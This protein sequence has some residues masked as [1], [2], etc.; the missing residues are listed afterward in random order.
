LAARSRS[1]APNPRETVGRPRRRRSVRSLLSTIAFINVLRPIAPR[2]VAIRAVKCRSRRGGLRIVV[3]GGLSFNSPFLPHLGRPPSRAPRV[4][5]PLARTS[6]HKQRV[7]AQH[8]AWCRRIHDLVACRPAQLAHAPRGNF[9]RRR[10]HV[11]G[12]VLARWSAISSNVEEPRA[13]NV[14][15]HYLCLLDRSSGLSGR[16]SRRPS[17]MSG[18]HRGGGAQPV[19]LTIARV[20]ASPFTFLFPLS[21]GAR[22][23]CPLIS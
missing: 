17:V 15:L 19:M 13:W 21:I 2:I 11:G 12:S 18:V 1:L 16:T 7:G 23:S 6:I 22:T 10:Q 3:T 20:F 4:L 8:R 9:F 14:V 5:V